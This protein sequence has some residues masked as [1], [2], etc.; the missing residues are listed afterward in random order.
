[1]NHSKQFSGVEDAMKVPLERLLQS[2]GEEP[3]PGSDFQPAGLNQ[4]PI[5]RE[6]R[7]SL[8]HPESPR[9][10]SFVA[11]SSPSTF[12]RRH[13]TWRDLGQ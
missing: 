11:T 2:H 1:M 5:Q 12:T 9:V 10:P 8:V 3:N 6:S 7:R 4:E 13:M